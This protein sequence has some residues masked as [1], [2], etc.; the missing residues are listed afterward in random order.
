MT[1]LIQN[2]PYGLCQCGCGNT[3][4]IIKGWGSYRTKSR[5]V[6]RRVTGQPAP[7]IVGHANRISVA[8]EHA[9]PF[10]IDGVYCRLVP[11]TQGQWAIVDE[12]DYAWLMQWK[13][14]ARWQKLTRSFYAIRSERST[15]KHK[16]ILMHRLIISA[17]SPH[18]DHVTLDN[19]RNNLR[20]ASAKES[21]YNQGPYRRN[22]SGFKG[23]HLAGGCK[24]VWL[25]KIS[26]RIIGRFRSPQDA[27]R[28]FDR[29]AVKLHG[30]FAWLNF[31]EERSIHEQALL[32][33]N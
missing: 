15:G 16:T 19:R 27:A 26:Y 4:K 9:F 25:A 12:A 21:R 32:E 22:K 1:T 29:E 17:T 24:N 10:K 30:E 18:V 33:S 11:L 23:V 20:P 14:S 7:Y 8:I 31:P 5:G 3:T 28:A 2:I 13:W 6:V